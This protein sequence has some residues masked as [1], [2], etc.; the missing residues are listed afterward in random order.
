MPSI[1]SWIRLEPGAINADDKLGLQARIHDPLW[2]LGRQW[3]M[4]EFEGSDGG[5][6]VVARLRAESAL[7]TRYRLGPA[8]GSATGL[9]YNGKIDPLETL[10]ER[11]PV[12]Q[13]ERLLL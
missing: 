3:Q 12:R 8:N 4:G 11:E 10:V 9:P 13:P 6:P 5:S 7:V 2:L 1:T